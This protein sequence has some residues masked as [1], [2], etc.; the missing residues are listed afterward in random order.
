MVGILTIFGVIWIFQGIRDF[1]MTEKFA[2][3][4]KNVLEQY[5]W[6]YTKG[7]GKFELAIGVL[8]IVFDKAISRLLIGKYNAILFFAIM[9]L[10]LVYFSKWSKKY[11]VKTEQYDN[12]ISNGDV[13]KK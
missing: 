4:K 11:T 8:F 5:R 3:T 12:D 10:I 9:I 2:E 13:T 6:E 7:L 1:F